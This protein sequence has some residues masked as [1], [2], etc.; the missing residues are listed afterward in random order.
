MY[1]GTVCTVLSDPTLCLTLFDCF[2][3][4]L[5]LAVVWNRVRSILYF[6]A[7]MDYV[8]FTICVFGKQIEIVMCRLL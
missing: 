2:P 1:F 8:I 5:N 3:S 6:V 4:F 7:N